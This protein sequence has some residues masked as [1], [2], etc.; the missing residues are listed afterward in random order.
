MTGEAS[1]VVTGQELPA[2]GAGDSARVTLGLSRAAV[3]RPRH[4]CATKGYF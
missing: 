4:K 1:A 2:H 3:V